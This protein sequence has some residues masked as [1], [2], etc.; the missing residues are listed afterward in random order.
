MATGTTTGVKTFA[1]VAALRTD[2]NGW[3]SNSANNL[4]WLVKD[5]LETDGSNATWIYAAKQNATAA[6]RPKLTVTYTGSPPWDSYD[7]GCASVTDTFDAPPNNVLCAK[8]TGVSTSTTY[9]IAYYDGAGAKVI[10]ESAVTATGGALQSS[11]YTI[12]SCCASSTQGTWHV[13]AFESAAT[14]PATYGA[15]VQNT[16]LVVADD[17]FTV[18]ALAIPELSTVLAAMGMGATA[19]AA[20]LWMRRRMVY[21]PA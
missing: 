15:I 5:T 4:G 2:V 17:T 1:D 16:D 3:V 12:S 19:A 20:Y 13:V 6:N 9:D 21:V 11:S 18:N 10:E 14:P 7:S 8:G